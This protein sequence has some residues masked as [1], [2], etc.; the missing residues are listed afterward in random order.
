MLRTFRL[1]A[2][3]SALVPLATQ[4]QT[5]AFNPYLSISAAAN[6]LD[7]GQVQS[8]TLLP[9]FTNTYSVTSGKSWRAEGGASI[10][11]EIKGQGP[12]NFQ[13]GL[14][15]YATQSF[16]VDG[17]IFNAATG[18]YNNLDYGY[19]IKHYRVVAEGKILF[20]LSDGL[21]LPY[22]SGQAGYGY[23]KAENYRET[24][25]AAGAFP[26][27][28][29][30]NHTESGFTYA[31]GAGVDFSVV[32][33]FRIGAGYQYVDLGSASLGTSPGAQNPV[34]L[35]AGNLSSH[36]IRIQFTALLT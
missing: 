10:G 29:F 7:A 8:L 1:A 17:Q 4:A 25:T 14:G 2:F 13:L 35:N 36:Q 23:N 12:V 5:G 32:E 28:P 26:M 9:P 11:T 27:P 20:K 18:A 34:S 16:P 22:L 21:I 33:Y 6:S 24:A 30:A 3:L 31:L 15:Y 19:R